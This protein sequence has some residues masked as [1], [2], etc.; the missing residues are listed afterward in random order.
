MLVLVSSSIFYDK[1]SLKSKLGILKLFSVFLKNKLLETCQ[2]WSGVPH[3]AWWEIVF[4]FLQFY[5]LHVMERKIYYNF[6]THF[7]QI[8]SLCHAAEYNIFI[9][10][11]L[12]SY[13]STKFAPNMFYLPNIN[14]RHSLIKAGINNTTSTWILTSRVG[15]SSTMDSFTM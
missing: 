1:H 3:L 9:W 14:M 6:I 13:N 7:M 4:N 8:C 15:S 5:T 10:V 2:M 12:I 11:D